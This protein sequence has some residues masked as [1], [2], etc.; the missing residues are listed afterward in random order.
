[1]VGEGGDHSVVL[2]V[3][4]SPSHTSS[5]YN[6]M[7]DVFGYPRPNGGFKSSITFDHVVK[8]GKQYE[9]LCL[10]SERADSRWR[11]TAV[12]SLGQFLSTVS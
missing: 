9:M 12:Y 5:R 3:T 4:S 10:L 1:M 6:T 8:R 11:E 2:S 7:Y